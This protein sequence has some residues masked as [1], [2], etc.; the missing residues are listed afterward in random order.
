MELLSY[1]SYAGFTRR[2]LAFIIDRI[3]IW[4]LFS[5]VLGY[6]E[7]ISIYSIGS[8]FGAQTIVVEIL[9]MV[10]FVACE[11][12]SWQGTLG[13]RLLNM[14]VVS[15]QYQKVTAAQAMW[16]FTWKYLSAFVF[17]LG[18][19]WVIFDARKQ[20]WHDKLAHTYV[21]EG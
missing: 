16:R 4:L 9:V 10:Y 17:L 5:V 21:I 3:L 11:T 14:K 8:L 6:A 13:K 1:N 15:E 20:G 18:F 12:S 2:L 7:G 19:I